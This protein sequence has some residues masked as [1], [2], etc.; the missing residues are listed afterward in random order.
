MSIQLASARALTEAQVDMLIESNGNMWWDGWTWV[1][2]EPDPR[3]AMSVAGS[4]H[5]DTGRP[6]YTRR[7]EVSNDGTWSVD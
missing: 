7:I 3:A 5:P 1:I 2:F 6:G 4:Y